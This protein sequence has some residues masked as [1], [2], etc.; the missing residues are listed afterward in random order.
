MV[1]RFYKNMI[2]LIRV[3]QEQDSNR[4]LCNLNNKKINYKQSEFLIVIEHCVI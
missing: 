3:R 1:D 4:T 2:E